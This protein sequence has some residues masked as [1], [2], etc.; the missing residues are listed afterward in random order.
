[1]VNPLNAVKAECQTGLHNSI[2]DFLRASMIENAR[3]THI[4]ICVGLVTPHQLD[5]DAVCKGERPANF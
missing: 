3:K 5:V 2:K 1:M 4:G